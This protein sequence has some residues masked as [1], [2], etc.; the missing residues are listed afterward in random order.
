[1]IAV[2][3][4]RGFESGKQK[5]IRS[6]LDHPGEDNVARESQESRGVTAQQIKR[7]NIEHDPDGGVGRECR[8]RQ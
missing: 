2:Q 6:G 8:L 1:M 3:E 5:M 4:L 7:T